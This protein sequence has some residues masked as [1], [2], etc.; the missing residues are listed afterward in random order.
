MWRQAP[1]ECLRDLACCLSSAARSM[2]IQRI[3]Q[4]HLPTSY[5]LERIATWR[6]FFEKGYLSREAACEEVVYEAVREPGLPQAH[7]SNALASCLLIIAKEGCTSW[8]GRS[9][10]YGTVEQGWISIL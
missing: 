10:R 6:E 7:R 8:C 1:H 9:T 5:A 4:M 2:L 3:E